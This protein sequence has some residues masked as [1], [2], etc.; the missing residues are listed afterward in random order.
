MGV[1][2]SSNAEKVDVT[3]TAGRRE[4]IEKSG[5]IIGAVKKAVRNS[6]GMFVNILIQ[7]AVEGQSKEQSLKLKNHTRKKTITVA[8][9]GDDGYPASSNVQQEMLHFLQE[10]AKTEPPTTDSSDAS[11]AD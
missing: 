3:F 2:K 8:R 11:D 7:G 10:L 1:A 6:I 9:D 5:G 4:S